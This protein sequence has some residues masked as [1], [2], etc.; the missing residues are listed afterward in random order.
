MKLNYK[1]WL[2]SAT[3]S[4]N[5]ESDW[6]ITLENYGNGRTHSFKVPNTITL[7]LA[8]DRA[9]TKVDEFERTEAN[10]QRVDAQVK[11]YWGK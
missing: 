2:I 3:P 8:E 11:K 5:H 4:P 7:K 9:F 6:D 1:G 10:I